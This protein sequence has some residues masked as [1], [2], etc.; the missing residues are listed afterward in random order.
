[1]HTTGL[2]LEGC[3]GKYC[4]RLLQNSSY[5]EPTCG[6]KNNKS[7]IIFSIIYSFVQA[8]PTGHRLS[9]GDICSPCND[10]AVPRDYMF[11]VF[12]V[13]LTLSGHLLILA[14]EAIK[15][16]RTRPRNIMY[17]SFSYCVIASYILL[18]ELLLVFVSWNAS[19]P[20]SLHYYYSNLMVN[21][22]FFQYEY[23][24]CFRKC[25]D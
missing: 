10:D 23:L 14:M 11:F 21:L 4:G 18:L 12:M 9:A 22:A 20:A 1:M 7:V 25:C 8:C 5:C 13:L 3:P 19:L 15:G 6:V 16:K 24:F 2:S 17:V